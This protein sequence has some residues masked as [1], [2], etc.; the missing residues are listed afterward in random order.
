MRCRHEV[1]TLGIS[2][3]PADPT[4]TDYHIIKR[5]IPPEWRL[6]ATSQDTHAHWGGI[7]GLPIMG[8]AHLHFASEQ[9][10]EA[11]QPE[12]KKPQKSKGM[13]KTSEALSSLC[14]LPVALRSL[15]QQC[16]HYIRWCP[17]GWS[18]PRHQG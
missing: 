15:Y 7:E 12:K 3:T 18:I 11:M 5:R 17:W 9:E 16:S 13:N 10:K 4:P 6:A 2:C 1:I 8:D 14:C